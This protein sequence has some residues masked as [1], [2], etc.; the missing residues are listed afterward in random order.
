MFACLF[1][2]KYRKLAVAWGIKI[3]YQE[4][5]VFNQ[6]ILHII[7]TRGIMANNNMGKHCNISVLWLVQMFI[8]LNQGLFIQLHFPTFIE[9][10]IVSL[11]ESPFTLTNRA[12]WFASLYTVSLR[13]LILNHFSTNLI[14]EIPQMLMHISG[15]PQCLLPGE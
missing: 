7:S 9:L 2:F 6:V 8:G 11:N 13:T 14:R 10:R 3:H 15:S 1:V 12:I 5:C 4:D